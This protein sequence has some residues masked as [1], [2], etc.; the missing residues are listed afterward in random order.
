MAS[1]FIEDDLSAS[2]AP[3]VIAGAGGFGREMAAWIALNFPQVPLLG[4]ID[5][6]R[7][8]D[9]VLGPI[10]GHVPLPDTRY[11]VAIGNGMGRAKVA[12]TLLAQGCV[13]VS[14]VS[15]SA[16]LCQTITGAKHLNIGGQCLISNDVR[17]GEHVLIQSF[18][19]IGHDAGIGRGATIGSRAFVGGG[20]SL[21]ELSTVH[22]GAIVLPKVRVGVNATVGAGAVVI[23]NVPDGATVFGNPARIIFRNDA[24]AP[25]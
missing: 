12:D 16:M 13:L 24:R 18:A 2:N 5:D 3:L 15:P 6:T 20:A 9:Q 11:L 14:F 8:A 19:C 25:A 4:F 21:G 7:P 17:V 22:P 1:A 10:Q 23:R